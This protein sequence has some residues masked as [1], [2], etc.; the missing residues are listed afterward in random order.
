MGWVG[1][2]V[3]IIRKLLGPDKVS[4]TSPSEWKDTGKDLT[5]KISV[6]LIITGPKFYN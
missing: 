2:K 3:N 1:Q 4:E 5:T 6:P